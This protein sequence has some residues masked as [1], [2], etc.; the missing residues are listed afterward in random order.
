MGVEN[1]QEIALIYSEIGED[2][3]EMLPKGPGVGWAVRKIDP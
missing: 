1:E 3:G 2:V